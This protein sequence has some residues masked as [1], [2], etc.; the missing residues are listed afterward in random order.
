MAHERR[1][2][3]VRRERDV[4]ERELAEEP[5]AAAELALEPVVVARERLR[6][7]AR[8]PSGSCSTSSG[9]VSL[10]I[11]STNTHASISLSDLSSR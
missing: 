3:Q 4:D 11:P 7:S 10:T 9:R 2:A 8:A 6:R 1:R 5:L